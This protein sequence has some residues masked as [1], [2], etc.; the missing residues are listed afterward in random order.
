LV[1]VVRLSASVARGARLLVV[2][3]PPGG[4]QLRRVSLRLPL[5]HS[6]GRRLPH[7]SAERRRTR[8]SSVTVAFVKARLQT[9]TA[10]WISS[11]PPWAGRRDIAGPGQSAAD[12]AR[13]L[14]PPDCKRRFRSNGGCLHGTARPSGGTSG[15]GVVKLTTTSCSPNGT[16]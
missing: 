13:H 5:R 7:C 1:L 6:L 4:R 16:V 11:S 10:S 9:A 8:T 12:R 15:T 2:G 14:V 3:L